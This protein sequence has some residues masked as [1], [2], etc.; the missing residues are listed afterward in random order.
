MSSPTVSEFERQFG[1]RL[2]QR[3]WVGATAAAAACRAAWPARSTGWLLGSIVALLTD[4]KETAL[5]LVQEHLASHPNDAQC[6]VQKAECLLGLGQRAAALAAARDAAAGAGET[7]ALLDSIGEFL[8]SANEHREALAIYHRAVAAAPRDPDLRT[9]RAIVQRYL[10]N[11]ELA[12]DDFEAVLAMTPGDAEALKELVELRE[13]T[14]ERNWTAPLQAALA[15]VAA[16]SPEAVLLH[17][18]LAKAFEDL[19]EYAASWRHLST[20]NVLERRRLQY[21]PVQDR[22]VIDRLIETFPSLEAVRSDTSGES[23]IFIVG[24]PRS[25]TTL[26]DQI[27]GSHSAV[28]SAGE[29][30]VLSETLFGLV[31]RGARSKP[32]DRLEYL[33]ALGSLDPAA[34]AREY[35]ARSHAQRAG[36]PR[37]TDK[38]TVNFFYCPL[39][40]RAFPNARVVHLTRHPLAAC[41]AIYK[42]HFRGT[43]PFANELSELADFYVGYRRLMAHWHKILPDRI[44]DLPYEEVVSAQEPTTRR[45]LAY[46]DLP[47]ET[48]CLEFHLNPAAITTASS[49]QVRQPLYASSLDRWRHF[50]TELGPL[51]A[52]LESA[53]IRID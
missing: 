4:Q 49:V 36:R 12:A 19:G 29:L 44:F 7:P 51:R 34:I 21:D 20:A 52:R 43:F 6:L 37:F 17:F 27:L 53:G 2:S 15:N 13:Q 38:Q 9:K 45:L 41:H 16:D 46:L 14:S 10:G 1:E 32:A 42:T 11:F 33:A 18:G 48:A 35:L 40:F 23:P 47:Y 22:A 26:V 28:H 39:I 25:G 3:D 24:L 50:A 5:A 31:E 8:V 30:P